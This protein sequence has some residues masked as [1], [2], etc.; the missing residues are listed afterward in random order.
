MDWMDRRDQWSDV[1][2][3]VTRRF[4]KAVKTRWDWQVR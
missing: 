3:S 4:A 1:G 2:F